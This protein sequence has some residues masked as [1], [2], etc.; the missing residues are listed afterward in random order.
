VL[1]DVHKV[2]DIY[3]FLNSDVNL[4]LCDPRQAI[5]VSEF[6]IC[7]RFYPVEHKNIR[8]NC[9]T[10]AFVFEHCLPTIIIIIIYPL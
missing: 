2:C 8:L 6:G 3:I 4:H 10:P 7:L 1:H 5:I 9:R